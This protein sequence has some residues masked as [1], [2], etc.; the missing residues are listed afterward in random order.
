MF[1]LFLRRSFC[2]VLHLWPDKL[3]ALRHDHDQIAIL[4]FFL[5]FIDLHYYHEIY[6]PILLSPH[7]S[8]YP[9]I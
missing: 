1:C 8:S 2:E 6:F 9:V 3:S 5:L 7:L 4:G